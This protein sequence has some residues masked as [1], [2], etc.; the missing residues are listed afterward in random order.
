LEPALRGLT[1]PAASCWFQRAARHRYQPTAVDRFRTICHLPTWIMNVAYPILLQPILKP[2]VWGGRELEKLGKNLPPEENIGESWELA[3]LPESIEGGRS[4]IANGSLAGLSLHEAIARHGS[5]IMGDAPLTP[6]GGFPLLIKYL[7]ARENLSVQVHP[8]AEYAAR[9]PES[10]LKSEA[11]VIVQAQPGSVIYVGVK[12]D[13]TPSQFAQHIHSGEIVNDLVAIKVK[14]GDC[15][16][17]PSGTCHALGGGI[18]VAEIQT[19]SDTTFRVYD[20]GRAGQPSRALHID[21]ALRCIHFGRPHVPQTPP[22][23]R[24]P[25]EVQGVR[26]AVLTATEHF[27]IERLEPSAEKRVKFPIVTSNMPEVWMMIAGTGKIESDTGEMVDLH[28]GTTV[29]LPAAMNRAWATLLPDSWLLRVKL[30]SPLHG[31]IA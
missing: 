20:W 27:Q 16:Y 21:Q 18:V 23:A 9:H 4:I 5:Q 11:W 3:D 10:H 28:A 29:L 13:V 24:K 1:S 22:K 19:P 17:L 30:P 12:P 7:D 2:K 26:S 25:L 8:S 14:P 6:E 15:H 31:M